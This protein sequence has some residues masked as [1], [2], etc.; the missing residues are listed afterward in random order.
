MR[1]PYLPHSKANAR[2]IWPRFDL[3]I[4]YGETFIL[5]RT[6][7]VQRGNIELATPGNYLLPGFLAQPKGAFAFVVFSRKILR[8]PLSISSAAPSK[9]W[10]TRPVIP[11]LHA[12]STK[13]RAIAFPIP[14]Q[15]PPENV[16]ALDRTT[17]PL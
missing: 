15:S 2:I 10:R 13:A 4:A 14:D 9:E 11:Y 3:L 8:T 1:T 17:W 5:Q 6:I 16:A 12:H 7:F